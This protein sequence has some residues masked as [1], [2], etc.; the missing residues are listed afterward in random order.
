MDRPQAA[1]AARV[2]FEVMGEATQGR[3]MNRLQAALPTE[4]D[5]L[6]R[7]SSTGGLPD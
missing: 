3:I 1:F 4:L 5:A 7:A 6:V 2:V